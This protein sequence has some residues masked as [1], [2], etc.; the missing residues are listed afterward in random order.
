MPEFSWNSMNLVSNYIDN[1]GII[2][3]SIKKDTRFSVKKVE[4]VY[5]MYKSYI[6]LTC[7]FQLR[8]GSF[9]LDTLQGFR[10]RF[11]LFRV[12]CRID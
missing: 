12:T 4:N 10:K 3:I 5:K 2:Y 9:I 1:S 8:R 7:R 11:S 6:L